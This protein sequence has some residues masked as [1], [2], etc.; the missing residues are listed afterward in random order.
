MRKENLIPLTEIFLPGQRLMLVD[1]VFVPVGFGGN[2]TPGKTIVKD[3]GKGIYYKCTSVGNTTWSGNK[4]FQ[5]EDGTWGFEDA[6]TSGLSFTEIKP[7]KGKVYSFDALVEVTLWDGNILP[8]EGLVFYA[9]LAQSGDAET[10]QNASR[11]DTRHIVHK[12][13]SCAYL[14]S[15]EDNYTFNM[16]SDFPTGNAPNTLSAWVC[17]E[18]LPYN[19][20]MFTGYGVS[21]SY[22]DQNSLCINNN[23]CIY[24]GVYGIQA[25]TSSTPAERDKWYCMTCVYDGV[26]GSLYINGVKCDTVDVGYDVKPNGVVWIGWDNFVPYYI[27]GV[28]VYNRVLTDDEILQLSQEFTPTA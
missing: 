13:I 28:R 20:N 21:N 12:G 7:E 8:Q 5:N 11:T 10:G 19:W 26:S 17:L 1:G 3:I 15:S 9:S 27:A 16:S 4:A 24:G 2:V 23:N 6:V 22:A 18:D 25:A 14:Q